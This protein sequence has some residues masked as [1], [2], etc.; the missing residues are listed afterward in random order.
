[1]IQIYNTLTRNKE[2]F[3]PIKEGKISMYLCGPTVYNYIHIGNARS[4]VAF[5]TI[6]RYFEYRGYEVTYVSNFTDVDDKIIQAAKE[7]KLEAP[8][9]A[10]KF[11]DAFFEDTEALAVRKAD[12]HP[13]VMQTIPEIIELV[14]TLIDKGFAYESDGD[15]YYRTNK[16][17]E[18]GKLSGIT[19]DELKV[20]ASERLEEANSERK[21][22]PI[23]FALWKKAKE[24]EISWDSPWGKGRPGWHIECSAMAKK[25][26]G[27]TIDIHAGGQDLQ[28]PHHENEIAQSE[29]ATGKQF[30]N[31]WMHNGFVTMGA[32]K[33]SKSIGNVK[34]VKDLRE[35]YDPQVLRFFLASAHY[36]RPLTYTEMALEDAKAN[37]QH[38]KTA[39]NNGW[40]R[41]KNT[42]NSLPSDKE[43][44][45]KIEE[46]VQQFTEAMDDD[47][48]AQ[49]GITVIYEMIRDLNVLIQQEEV[50]HKVLET[51]LTTLKQLLAIFGLENL[52]ETEELLDE[53]IDALIQERE[54]ART[55]K[56]FERADEIRDQLKEEGILLEDTAQGIR[57]KR[58]ED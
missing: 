37:V 58:A 22:A 48:Q 8:Q 38:I 40:H 46:Y 9:V 6:R 12:H 26:L 23:D 43:K 28:F 52:T 39:I 35:T 44:F 54:Q 56:N 20:G 30:A 34:L 18:Y 33:M 32:E 36:R 19:I 47:F 21:E 13:R 1:M 57:W 50:S 31:Y 5:D 25:Y 29:A 27:E 4:T 41:L 14:Q 24:D 51:F 16:F 10:E 45:A 53:E 49:N 15:V 3:V 11:I 17:E 42:V 7:L 55:D 2:T